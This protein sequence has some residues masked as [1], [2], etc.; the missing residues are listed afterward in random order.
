MLALLLSPRLAGAQASGSPTPQDSAPLDEVTVRA[1]REI[2][3]KTL[4]RVIV[5][6][7]VEAHGSPSERI[8]QVGRWEASICPQTQGLDALS[9]EYVSRRVVTVARL[10][11]A[12]TKRAGECR[13]DVDIIFSPKPQA[14]L[15]Y[16]ANKNRALLGYSTEP[17]ALRKF[18]HP[19]Q[20]WY[21]TGT[22]SFAKE[23][24]PFNSST[25][26]GDSLQS[27]TGDAPPEAGL[28]IDS[29]WGTIRGE[30]GSYLTGALRSEFV[31]VTVIVDAAAVAQ[32]SLQQV[33][34]YIAVLVLTH[35]AL[36]G[37]NPLPSI[38]DMLSPDCEGRPSPGAITEA[39]TAYLKALYSSNLELNLNLEHGEL[40]SRMLQEI[41]S[42]VAK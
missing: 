16:I 31:H 33:S 23:K 11:G 6:H 7:F 21:V 9:N 30:A 37:C 12:P 13:T 18:S 40:Q 41:E 34:D 10:V 26:G 35:T 28:R 20:A 3:R 29:Q 36:N 4:E 38:V 32:Y 42:A 2:D 24:A 1:L 39:D 5:P 17:V 15:D 25:A 22:R 8:A 19:I 14:Q 27:N